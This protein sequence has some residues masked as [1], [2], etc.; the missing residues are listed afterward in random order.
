MSSSLNL[1]VKKF[2]LEVASSVGI[3]IGSATSIRKDD[4]ENIS[5]T[6]VRRPRKVTRITIREVARDLATGM[7][8]ALTDVQ[9]YLFMNHQ[10]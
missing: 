8:K 9:R 10:F 5:P 7:I 1:K 4:E 3:S 2:T 6:T